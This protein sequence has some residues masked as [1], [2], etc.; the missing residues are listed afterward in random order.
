M[1]ERAAVFLLAVMIVGQAAS[2]QTFAR[3]HHPVSTSNSTAQAYFDQGLT[4]IYAFNREASRRAFQQAAAA[5][6]KLAMAF[7]GVAL[8]YGPNINEGIT[9]AGERA[10]M[11]A[12]ARAESLASGGSATGEE[13]ALIAALAQ[14]YS[15][16]PQ[17]DGDAL[18]NAYC[19]AMRAVY[20]KYP[21]DS[22]AAALFAESEMDLHPWALYTTAGVPI[23]GTAEIVTTLETVLARDPEHIGANHFLIHA[24]EASTSPERAL[25]SAFRLR[26]MVFEPA[27]AHLVHMPAH[28]FMRTGDYADAIASNVAATMH[29]RSAMHEREGGGY[30]GHDLFF[31]SSAAAMQGDYTAARRAAAE[32]VGQDA[33][34]PLLFVYV[35]FGR[36]HDILAMPA[37]K[38]S[39][40]EP[41]R[42]P[43]WRFARG[44]ASVET[45]DLQGARGDLAAV[46][47][48][49]RLMQVQ[50]VN[51]F[52]NGSHEILGVARDL[53]GAKLAWAASDRSGAI[54]KLSD[55]VR[56]QDSFLYIEPPD[57]YGPAREALGAAYCETGDFSRA[58]RVFRDDLARN[59]RNPR[60]LFG[61]SIALEGEGSADDAAYV[62]AQFTRGW[63]GETLSIN[64]LF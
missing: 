60:S 33:I 29:D 45:G 20:H 2:A 18:G 7:W 35:R 26:R 46:E 30:F 49:Y 4:L 27:A 41:L 47:Q 57:W 12:I 61:L 59:P 50:S 62:K 13:R 52:L 37:P 40:N 58:E 15:D 36:W 55:A 9:P 8:S 39:A 63:V 48:F 38:D 16:K 43:V 64:D 51:G 23:A 53:L 44:M 32:M 22:D 14:R 34:E 17:S 3:A 28:T 21:D 19:D 31:L 56:I 1:L 5:D 25:P 24:T 6:P 10:A 42:M 11:A 54:D